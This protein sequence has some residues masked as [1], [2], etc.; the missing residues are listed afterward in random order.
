MAITISGINNN[1]QIVATDGTIDALS[2]FNVVGVMTATTFSGNLV[3]N[4]TGNL[5]GNVN[6]TSNLLLQIGGSEKFRVASSGQ[7]G[8]GGA[9]YGTSGQVLTSGGSGSA[10]SW[11]TPDAGGVTTDSQGNTVGGTNSGDSFASGSLYTGAT[12]NTLFGFDTGTDITSGYFNDCFGYQAGAN[13]NSGNY[14][15]CIGRQ[16][17]F[18]ITTQ[19]KIIA[20]G[21]RSAYNTLG[22]GT[23]A[24]GYRALKTHN[25]TGRNCVVGTE[26]GTNTQGTASNNTALGN[27][28][29]YANS[30]G[31]SNC[32]IGDQ[33]MNRSTTGSKNVAI[34]KNAGDAILRTGDNNIMIGYYADASASDVSNEITLGDTNINHVRIPGIGVSFSEG[35]A[36]IS[37][38]VTATNFVKT[39]GSSLGGLTSDAQSNTVGGSGAGDSFSGTDAENNTL[40]G[41]NAGTSINSGDK[42]TVVGSLAGDALNTGSENTFFG[43]QAGSG[44]TSQ[45]A[46]TAVGV[47]ALQSAGGSY[48]T[49]I[50]YRAGTST[51]GGASQNVAIGYWALP[52]VSGNSNFA[53]GT[54]A[55][56]AR[57]TSGSYNLALG[58]MSGYDLGGGQKNV[59][60]GS[61]SG[62]EINGGSF[63]VCLG[64]E[65]GRHIDEGVS[66]NTLLGYRAGYNVDGNNNT[67]IGSKEYPSNTVMHG[68]VA[69]GAGTTEYVR[70]NSTGVGI[71]TDNPTAELEVVDSQ[72]HQSYMRGSSTVG[73]IRFGNSAYTNGYIYYDNGP[74][75]NFNVGGSERL[76]ITG[77]GKVGI[78]IINPESKLTVAGDSATAQ[79]EIKRTNTNSGGSIGALN[80]T[81]LDGHS[82]ANMFAIADGDNEG[83]HLVF[84]TTTAAGENSPYG[85]NTLERLRITNV[86]RV[87]IGGQSGRSPGGLTPQLQIEGIDVGT[88]SM[89]LTRNSANSGGASLILNKTRGTAVNADTA[90]KGNDTLGIIQFAGN[91]GGDSDNAAAW[92]LAKVDDSSSQT[93]TSNEMPGRLEFYTRSDTSSGSLLERLRI[94]STGLIYVNRDGVGGR[95]DATAGDASIKILDGNGRSSIKVS[96][97]GSGNSYEWELTT[98]G[99]FK[100]PSG[101]TIGIDFSAKTN[102]SGATDTT[103]AHYEEGTWTPTLT[104]LDVPGH[105]TTNWAT[106]T[107]VGR[108]V[109]ISAKF[110]ISSSVNDGSGFGFN[111]PYNP[112]SSRQIVIPAISDRSGTNKAPFAFNNVNSGLIVYAKAL[113]GYAFQTY[114]MFSGNYI[115]VT[116]SYET[117]A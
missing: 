88:S 112:L 59:F 49:A 67:I 32:A 117:D 72:Y 55:M 15:V 1:D 89:S 58:S 113:E 87:Y 75:M 34:G 84:K 48:N 110:T 73:G 81:A 109:T 116:G 45:T 44:D 20:I 43:Y 5:T 62:R 74:N 25:G 93:M 104:N 7:L 14:N 98:A 111:L 60:I 57:T 21:E 85:S 76:R 64:H 56:G 115:I 61:S 100:A 97:P 27:Y 50:G 39:D 3:G 83:A 2:G 78:G 47:F 28:A 86:G 29:F 101:Q 13:I 80:F 79:I 26:A 51:A 40:I 77:T 53:V 41:K 102:L 71:G 18:D 42:N 10:A 95:I 38:I 30:T 70:I 6:A 11:T 4:V 35:G 36:V 52:Y 114:N 22:T 23:I 68:Q 17:G 9:N 37:G 106:Y 8:I 90:V 46:N 65:A 96:D 33:A 108:I 92:I 63:N 94:G 103:L 91:D 66:G 16:A 69:I 107:R 82:V 105:V 99:N 54:F 12:Q 31:V 24:I 19:S